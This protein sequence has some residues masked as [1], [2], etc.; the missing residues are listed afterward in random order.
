MCNLKKG[1][2]YNWIKVEEEKANEFRFLSS[3]TCFLAL[4]R[5]AQLFI[6]LRLLQQT[7]QKKNSHND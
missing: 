2:N 7:E 1:T 3:F 6:L 4:Q 5:I